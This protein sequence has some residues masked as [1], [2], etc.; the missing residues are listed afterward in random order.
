MCIF[1]IFYN[2]KF[3]PK[4]K[5]E[6]GFWTFLKMSKKRGQKCFWKMMKSHVVTDLVTCLF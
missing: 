2:N 4:S 3:F 5:K 1:L 6:N